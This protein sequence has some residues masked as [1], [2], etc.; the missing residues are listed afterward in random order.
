MGNEII[1]IFRIYVP[2]ISDDVVEETTQS[3]E[4]PCYEICQLDGVGVIYIFIYIEG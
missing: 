2:L 4:Q 3:L 1:V